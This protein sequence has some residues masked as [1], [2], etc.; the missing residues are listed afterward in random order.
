M[1]A[2]ESKPIPPEV[3]ELLQRMPCLKDYSTQVALLAHHDQLHLLNDW[4]PKDTDEIKSFFDQLQVLQEN[5]AGGIGR[6]IERARK[7]LKDA[8][9][10]KTP[11]DGYI[12]E[13]PKGCTLQFASDEYKKMEQIGL[14]T[15]PYLGFVLV[16]G[17]L[18]ERLG[19]SGIKIAL[20]TELVTGKFYMQ[21]FV[22]SILSMQKEAIKLTGDDNLIIPLAIMTSHDTH[23]KT[24]KLFNDNNNFGMARGQITL[25]RQEK[26]ACFQDDK[27]RL[28][29]DPNNK[30]SILTKPHGHGDVHEL[31]NASGVAEK[32]AKQGK[33]YIAFFQ[34][35]NSLVFRPM[36]ASV[37]VSVSHNLACN[38]MSGPRQPKREMGAI[39]KLKK[40]DGQT[41]TCNVEY[42][43]LEPMLIAAGHKDGD[44]AGGDGFSP[45]PGNMNQLI[46]HLPSYLSIL[47]KEHVDGLVPEFVN[48]KYKDETR[49]SFKK[50]ARLECMMQDLPR[51]F[52]E[53]M[54]VGFTTV[55]GDI[56]FYTPVKNNIKDAAIK[57]RKNM[58]PGCASAGEADLYTANAKILRKIGVT[59]A[60]PV[61]KVY[62]EGELAI[63]VKDWP[64]VVIAP[65][66]IL[67]LH[68]W[69]QL[70]PTPS[71][72]VISAGSSL[73][74]EGKGT[75]VI[76][77]L[78]LDGSLKLVSNDSESVIVIDKLEVKN[79][80]S[81]YEKLDNSCQDEILL[82]RGYKLKTD[83]EL[84]YTISGNHTLT[85]S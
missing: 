10:G 48:P 26:V 7:L 12:P 82:M 79:R 47:Q 70:F 25:M 35:T 57:Q 73:V 68:H 6:Y 60:D 50:P 29:R 1:G 59:V 85:I 43:L 36:L 56:N 11:F 51:K 17:G 61:E 22:E 54:Q 2:E 78:K 41:M 40:S 37:G 53:S 24:L 84:I 63:T 71:S 77:E 74:I 67:T 16:A 64:H 46:F 69:E 4:D 81:S 49:T 38:S 75:V 13:I 27:A 55:Q 15:T 42:N 21:L 65:Y 83:E 34:D 20:P 33:R 66:H 52:D 72:V 5:Y 9:D 58:V 18:G 39:V 31:M 32:W 14:E 80:G 28:A 19:F 30:Y 45:Y 8:A 44:V 23:D 3:E 62:G 76:K